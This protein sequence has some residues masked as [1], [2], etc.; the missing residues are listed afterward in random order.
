MDLS[1]YDYG[2]LIWTCHCVTMGALIWTCHFLT[3][4]DTH[5]DLSFSEYGVGQLWISYYMKP[6]AILT[7][8]FR[9]SES[10]LSSLIS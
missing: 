9:L 1:L 4:G 5:M 3:M 10:Q 2:A 7:D 8:W 6:Q